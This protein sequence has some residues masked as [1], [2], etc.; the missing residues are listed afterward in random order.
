MRKMPDSWDCLIH[1]RFVPCEKSGSVATGAVHAALVWKRLAIHLVSVIR[2]SRTR[3]LDASKPAYALN[4]LNR[5]MLKCCQRASIGV[6]RRTH[7]TKT[8]ALGLV[9]S[10]AFHH[11]RS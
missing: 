11:P 8:R 7:V 10:L 6:I 5:W 9:N 2:I 4:H 1:S 3:C